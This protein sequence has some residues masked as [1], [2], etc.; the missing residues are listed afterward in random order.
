VTPAG[1]GRNQR[2]EGNCRS[3]LGG[4]DV[5]L[6]GSAIFRSHRHNGQRVASEYTICP[7]ATHSV[8]VQVLISAS[9]PARENGLDLQ[10]DFGALCF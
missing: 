4:G 5:S 3:V 10:H 2:A 7:K 9:R 8:F 6:A 1:K